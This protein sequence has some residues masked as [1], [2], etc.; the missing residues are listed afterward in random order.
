MKTTKCLTLY[1]LQV[2]SEFINLIISLKARGGEIYL[3]GGMLKNQ[4]SS[5]DIDLYVEGIEYKDLPQHLVIAELSV[6]FALEMCEGEP[7]QLL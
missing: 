1:Q 5:H 2:N 3:H 7:Y 4:E 6:R